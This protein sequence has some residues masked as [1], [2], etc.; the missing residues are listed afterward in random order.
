M[1]INNVG[2]FECLHSEGFI[3][4]SERKPSNSLG[5]IAGMSVAIVVAFLLCG[6]LVGL[7]AWRRWKYVLP[8]E[9]LLLSIKGIIDDVTQ[10]LR[11]HLRSKK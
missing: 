9:I 5:L 1:C 7:Y 2:S 4:E 8:G 6:T 11:I 3:E 10:S